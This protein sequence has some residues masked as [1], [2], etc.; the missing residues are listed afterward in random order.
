[1][2]FIQKEEFLNLK[3][4]GKTFSVI[5]EYR[6]DEITPITIFN[7]LEGEKKFI[8]ESG[9][10]SD[11]FG[12]YSFMGVNPFK[13]IEGDSK[14][15]LEDIKKE[16]E[17]EFDIDTNPFPFKG[18]AI[19]YMGYES[20]GFYEEKLTFF[21]EDEL[22]LPTVKFQLYKSYITF[23]HYTHK[24]YIVQ[25]IY[26]DDNRTYEEIQDCSNERYKKI[27]KIKVMEEEKCNEGI[28]FTSN[29]TK[30]SYMEMVNKAK[31]YIEIGD[32]FQVVPSQRMKC[33]TNKR[34]LEIYRR[35]REENP[36]PYMYYMNFGDFQVVGSSPEILVSVQEGI[37]TT[38]PIAGTIK[39][40]KNQIEDEKLKRI[41]IRDEKEVAE[42]AMLVDLG[43]NDIGK[44]SEIGTVEVIDFMNI[45]KYSHV[46]HITS[47]VQGKM[48][49]ELTA[50]DALAACL[51]AGTLSGAPKIR[52]MEIIEELESIRRGIYGGAIG[53]FS[54]GGNMDM[55][56]AIRTI[57]LKE[58]IAYLQ[59]GGGV[60]YDSI[61]E[62][63]YEES[64]NKL[65]TIKEALK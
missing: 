36:S 65:E 64:L 45:E 21:N 52:A 24:V 9:C 19:G 54:L 56:I 44:V 55:A 27:K 2:L 42:H 46:M 43:R 15:I 14:G 50:F 57:V 11:S 12:R 23:D 7:T 59:A 62:K 39:R 33:K 41:L 58:K 17:Y 5:G 60:V 13:E 38:N 34:P 35:L 37:V 26:P 4:K 1:M 10:K 22:K 29:F 8:L 31:K 28:T 49:K 61:P 18:G 30:E 3:M 53:Y 51:P 48:K 20:V 32:I 47:K 63:E 40:G 6:G 16:M 25:N